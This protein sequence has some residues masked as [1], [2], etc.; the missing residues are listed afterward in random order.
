MSLLLSCTVI[1][2]E[3]E[4]YVGDLLNWV[5]LGIQPRTFDF[6]CRGF[7]VQL[8][9]Y[10]MNEKALLFLL[11]LYLIIEIELSGIEECSFV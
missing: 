7:F 8:P 11:Y 3:S 9:H 2:E 6:K 5:E 1:G 4:A 10:H